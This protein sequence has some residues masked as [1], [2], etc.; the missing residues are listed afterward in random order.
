MVYLHWSH[1]NAQNTVAIEKGFSMLFERVFI[2]FADRW[3]A[4]DP[5]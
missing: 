5:K 3:A 1:E 2:S 4:F